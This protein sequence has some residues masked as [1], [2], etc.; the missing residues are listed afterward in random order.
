MDVGQIRLQTWM[1]PRLETALD[2]GCKVGGDASVGLSIEGCIECNMWLT[3]RPEPTGFHA[4][5]LPCSAVTDP[6]SSAQH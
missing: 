1:E 2:R 3:G 4:C 5:A 6:E